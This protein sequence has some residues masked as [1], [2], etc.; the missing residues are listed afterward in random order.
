MVFLE[1]LADPALLVLTG[2]LLFAVAGVPGLFA[3]RSARWGEHV[4]ALLCV[5]GAVAGLAGAVTILHGGINETF[6]IAW[7]LPFGSCEIGIDPLSALFLLPVFL[8][9]ACSTCYAR[10]YWP[11]AANPNSAHRLAFFLGLFTAAMALVVM[12]RNSVLFLMAWEVMALAAYFLLTAENHKQEVRQAGMVYLVA[13]HIGTLALFVM[14]ILLRGQADSYLFSA[15]SAGDASSTLSTVIFVAALVGFGMKA[16]L[17]PLHIW[18][19]A[20]HANAPSH[21]SAIMSGVMLKMGIYGVIRVLSFFPHPPLWW[22]MAVLAS[23][24]IAGLLG[25]IFAIGQQDLKRLLAYSSIENIGIITI[26]IGTAV[27]GKATGNS[28]LLVLGMA[29][30]LLHVLN[31]SLFKSLLFLG[32]GSV[33]HA[34]NT[35]KLELLGGLASRMPLTAMLSLLGMAALCGL[36]P[37]NGFVSEYLLYA[38]FFSSIPTGSASAV[39]YLALSAVVLALIG[40][41]AVACFVR[42]YGIAFSSLPR[43]AEAAN[44][45]EAGWEMLAPMALLALLCVAIGLFPKIAVELIIPAVSADNLPLLGSDGGATLLPPLG[46]LTALGFILLA[47][48]ALLFGFSQRGLRNRPAAVTGTWGCGYL[49]PTPR[50]QYT[51]SSFAEMLVKLFG[52]ALRPRYR[53]PVVTGFFPKPAGFTSRYRETLLDLAIFPFFSMVQERFSRLRKLQHGKLPVYILYIFIT[54]LLLLLWSP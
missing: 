25:V 27:I 12:A 45:H 11:A 47:V 21:I 20:A 54:L 39:L 9:P 40:G 32:A 16:G 2:T 49:N 8:I 1:T 31:H 35:R 18:L 42:V 33:L 46:W 6:V 23:G 17:M 51:A 48:V 30:A 5:L 7:T 41:L 22:G 19:P 15:M 53:Q 50:I 37:L 24:V 14:F 26:G 44:A 10:G 3:R 34:A 36:P 38:G 4:A 28:A 43:S 52:G 13:T 29:G